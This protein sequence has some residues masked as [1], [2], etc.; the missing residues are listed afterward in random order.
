[1]RYLVVDACDTMSRMS[2]H[3]MDDAARGIS[4]H[5]EEVLLEAS[6]KEI[7]DVVAASLVVVSAIMKPITETMLAATNDR[8]SRARSKIESVT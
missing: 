5:L 3:V 7:D 8:H 6:D 4:E 1:M 2:D